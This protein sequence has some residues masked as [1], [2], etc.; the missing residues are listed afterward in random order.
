MVTVGSP[1]QA[2]DMHWR[3]ERLLESMCAGQWILL[4]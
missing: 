2:C 4:W 3:V 1:K